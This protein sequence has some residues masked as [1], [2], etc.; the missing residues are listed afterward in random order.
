MK[1]III[2][3]LLV[4]LLLIGLTSTSKASGIA[5]SAAGVRAVSLGGAYRALSGDWS[6]GYWNPA[7][8]TQV[9]NWNIGGSISFIAPEAKLTLYPYQGHRLF[10]FAYREATSK[11]KTFVI[12]NLGAVKTLDNGLSVGLGVFVPFGL[13][14]TWDLYNPVPGFGNKEDFP[15]YDNLS[16]MQVLDFQLSLAYPVTE[17]LSVGGGFG[18]LYTTLS[19]EQTSVTKIASLNPMLAPLAIAPHEHFPAQQKLDVSGIS[20]AASFGLQFKATEKLTLGL[21][22]RYYTDVPLKGSITADAYFP[23][24]QGALNTLKGLKAAGA[25]SDADYAVASTLF[26][27][28]KQEIINQDNIEATMP[29][30]LN[31]GGGVAFRPT[32]KLLISADVEFTQWSV[33]DKIDIKD[34]LSVKIGGAEVAKMKTELKENWS[35]GIRYN[36]GMEYTLMKSADRDMVLRLGYYRDPSPIPDS[37]IGPGIPDI[38]VKNSVTA[39]LGYTLGKI[40]INAVYSHI[41]IPSRDVKK[42]ILEPNGNNE[43]WAGH[44]EV[45]DNEFHIGLNYNF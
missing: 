10:G 3:P 17:K 40:T 12:P 28:T 22:A 37:S 24:D 26:S 35:D 14:S 20:Y 7:G 25:L 13:G 33:W 11:P 4:G 38:S 16:N 2:T 5:V 39:G 27:G 34:S 36:V 21:A 45:T 19:M 18:V 44:Y 15:K 9:K 31:L 41:F 42:W 8:L 29:L 43:N 6:G 30:P 32:D 1:K 23:Y